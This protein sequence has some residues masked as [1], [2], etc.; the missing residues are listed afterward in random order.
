MTSY[1]NSVRGAFL[2]GR[3]IPRS[4]NMKA[5]DS[6][7][8]QSLLS[9]INVEKLCVLRLI[10]ASVEV[11]FLEISNP[12]NQQLVKLKELCKSPETSIDDI[13]DYILKTEEFLLIYRVYKYCENIAFA[14]Q[15]FVAN[16]ESFFEE[17]LERY[18]S[19]Q[20]DF[21]KKPE[22]YDY[23][24][25]L[26]KLK[27]G[28]YERYELWCRAYAINL[29]YKMCIDDDKILTY[30][31]RI[32]G[33]ADP[34][35]QL[36]PNFSLELK[37]NFGYGSA[38][39]FYT[40]L[41]YK[42]IDITPFSDWV[43]YRFAQFNEIVRY[44]KSH[45]LEQQSWYDAMSFTKDACNLSLSD[46]KGFV[47]KYIIGECESMVSGLEKIL[48]NDEIQLKHSNEFYMKKFVGHELVVFRGEKI[49]G[50]LDF[51]S[52]ILQF[53]GIAHMSGF[54]KRIEKSNRKLYPYLVSEINFLEEKIINATQEK[55]DLIPEY[56][57]LVQIN[58]EYLSK[59]QYLRSQMILSGQLDNT[60]PDSNIL[61][62]AFKL[63]EPEY[64]Q[65]AEKYNIIRNKYNE[66]SSTISTCSEY[67]NS[68]E[69]SIN[70]VNSY[71][72]EPMNF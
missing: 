20:Y 51:I 13:F 43:N 23:L 54:V 19:I 26:S 35:Y 64:D 4:I 47:D 15:G 34:I 9:A 33:W 5:F 50:A 58:Q 29:A 65:F 39:Y 12:L 68:I 30:S 27:L 70:K 66:L 57:V 67:K 49:S 69:L 63:E 10:D 14:Y 37:T 56:D 7:D 11:D 2:N 42:N 3:S 40:R 18:Q 72:K 32:K 55:I 36:T 24:G 8:F 71:F 28:I 52:K 44:S 16:R 1:S 17:I 22:E 6:S 61:D 59:K 46:E 48:T 25:E 31:H 38:S 53:E 21:H 60:A 62:K 45:I 41:K